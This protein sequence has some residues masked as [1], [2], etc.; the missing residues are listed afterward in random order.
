MKV[1]RCNNQ[2]LIQDLCFSLASYIIFVIQNLVILYKKQ[3]M[4][5]ENDKAEIEAPGTR[6]D[7]EAIQ[8]RT[9]PDRSAGTRRA[10]LETGSQPLSTNRDDRTGR[11]LINECGQ[12]TVGGI[13]D[14]L[15]SKVSDEIEEF[16]QRTV[17]R[18]KYL[19]ELRELSEELHKTAVEPQ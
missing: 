15:I 10:S 13:V 11:N 4:V 17:D 12:A 5:I 7:K 8:P 6:G 16:E 9:H 3:I 18:K 19:Q 2:Y 14:R 1:V